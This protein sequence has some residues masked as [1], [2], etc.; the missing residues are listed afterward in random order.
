M[1]KK[2]MAKLQFDFP[3]VDQE[4]ILRQ[5]CMQFSIDGERGSGVACVGGVH[6]EKT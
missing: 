5:S 3:Q 2:R 6:E 4:L 1:K